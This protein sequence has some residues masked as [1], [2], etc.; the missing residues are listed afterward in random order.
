M[1]LIFLLILALLN[2]SIEYGSCSV[3]DKISKS[4]SLKVTSPGRCVY[5]DTN[6]FDSKSTIQIYVTV[7]YGYLS[8]ER[9]Y[10]ESFNSLPSQ[11]KNLNYYATV[12]HYSSSHYYN[13]YSY[14]YYDEITYYYKITKPVNRYLYI[15]IPTVSYYSWGYNVE[16]GV[17]NPLPLWLI[18]V[19]VCIVII[20]GI[21][22]T[23]VCRIY[24]RR[25]AS[26]ISPPA[27]YQQPYSPMPG[28]GVPY[29]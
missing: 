5:L 4:S 26:Y 19:I 18:I 13:E 2:S 10:Y 9:L 6:E 23:T 29:Y 24:K 12:D 11:T 15:S 8:M 21:I 20:V 1:K 27:D 22:I 28:P 16:I 14:Y 17:S 3:Y 7:L 25:R